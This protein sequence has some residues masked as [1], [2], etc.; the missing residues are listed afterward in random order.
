MPTVWAKADA[1]QAS[2]AV[3]INAVISLHPPCAG[4]KLHSSEG[5]MTDAWSQR[6]TEFDGTSVGILECSS[7]ASRIRGKLGIAV[8]RPPRVT[9]PIAADRR[10]GVPAWIVVV[11]FTVC[12]KPSEVET[13]Q[14]PVQVTG[15]VPLFVA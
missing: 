13:E 10:V 5:P 14:L 7:I 12:V 2:N 3:S 11:Q 9:G 6:S 15:P 8:W 1:E 4:A